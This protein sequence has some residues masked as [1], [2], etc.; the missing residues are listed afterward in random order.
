MSLSPDQLTP[1]YI[2]QFIEE[3]S[4]LWTLKRVEIAEVLRLLHDLGHAESVRTEDQLYEAL[5]DV[6]YK[7]RPTGPT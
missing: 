4:S 6:M 1:A 5:L 2:Q 7:T 3:D